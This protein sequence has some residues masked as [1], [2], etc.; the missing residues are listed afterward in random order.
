MNIIGIDIGSSLIKIIEAN[1][2]LQII[3][4]NILEKCDAKKVLNDFIKENTINIK[5]V[6]KIVLTGI[7][8]DKINEDLL[9]IKTI[10]VDELTAI[11]MGGTILTDKNDKIIISIGT[12]T[13][14]IKHEDGKFTHIGGTGVGGGT[15]INLCEVLT[16]ENNVDRIKELINKGNINNVNLVIKDVSEKQT[17]KLLSDITVSNLGKLNEKTNKEDIVVGILN[18][19]MEVIGM[20]A[21]FTVQGLPYKEVVLTGSFITCPKAFD[22]IKRIEMIQNVKFVMPE[23]PEFATIL[24]A[25]KMC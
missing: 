13:A 21:A 18:M 6:S 12:G 2:K 17:D 25:I 10:K 7:G 20:M 22:I 16:G 9:G 14:F 3:N 11:G 15:F 19:V 5:K 8:A 4:S 24:G 1:E 23:N